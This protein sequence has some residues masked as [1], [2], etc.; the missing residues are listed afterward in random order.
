M[1]SHPIPFPPFPFG[2]NFSLGLFAFCCVS[3]SSKINTGLCLGLIIFRAFSQETTSFFFGFVWRG[4]YNV[5]PSMDVHWESGKH[6][7]PAPKTHPLMEKPSQHPCFAL[8]THG[9]G[10]SPHCYGAGEAVCVVALRPHCHYVWPLLML[11]EQLKPGILCQGYVLQQGCTHTY[12]AV[13][14][15]GE[16]GWFSSTLSCSSSLWAL[17][18]QMLQQ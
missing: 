10:W 9:P 1:T 17:P 11:W 14:S 2:F 7:L 15:I 12:A 18:R 6:R 3:Q 13:G 5:L 8:G 4:F 16:G